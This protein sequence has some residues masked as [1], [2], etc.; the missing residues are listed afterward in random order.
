LSE[1]DD[2]QTQ[3]EP[4]QRVRQLPS[5]LSAQVARKAERLVAAALAEDGMRR[6]HFAVLTSLSEQGPASQS[7]LGR[8]LWIDRSDLHAILNELERER[9]VER[10]RDDRDRRKNVVSLTRHGRAALKRLDKRV[11]KAQEALLGPLSRAE[12][13]DL[14]RLLERLVDDI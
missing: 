10:A 2:A 3:Y 11:D 7:A 12:Q 4:P 6:Q 8:R 1:L 13:R 9:L 14:R 5:W